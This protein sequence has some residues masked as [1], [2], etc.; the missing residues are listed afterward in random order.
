MRK[1]LRQTKTE[2][3]GD[4]HLPS[5]RDQSRTASGCANG[6]TESDH[7]ESKSQES[8]RRLVK[9]LARLAV[10]ERAAMTRSKITDDD[11]VPS[12]KV[13]SLNQRAVGSSPTAPTNATN[14]TSRFLPP[15]GY[16]G[17][18]D[19]GVAGG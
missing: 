11:G 18:A 14:R 16:L 2:G 17:R 15:P 1:A 3:D 5:P 9:A 10:H 19:S 4:R 12:A 6:G 8:L 13:L 7:D